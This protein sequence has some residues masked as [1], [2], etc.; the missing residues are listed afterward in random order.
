MGLSEAAIRTVLGMNVGNK[1]A[2]MHSNVEWWN[3]HTDSR[4]TAFDFSQLP[5]CGVSQTGSG[6]FE[7]TLFR[8]TIFANSA[9]SPT[10]YICSVKPHMRQQRAFQRSLCVFSSFHPAFIPTTHCALSQL[11]LFNRTERFANLKERTAHCNGFC[12]LC[13]WNCLCML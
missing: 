6:S 1:L 11:L 9:L 5:T 3:Q 12:S 10:I 13:H 2:W 8:K 7:G 4:S